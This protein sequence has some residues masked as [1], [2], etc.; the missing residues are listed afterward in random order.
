MEQQKLQELLTRRRW[1]R[2]P[3]SV[4]LH[5]YGAFFSSQ[6]VLVYDI[7]ADDLDHESSDVSSSRPTIDWSSS[8]CKSQ[9]IDYCNASASDSS[10]LRRIF[11]DICDR[12]IN[13]SI[14]RL[15]YITG[16]LRDIF[17]SIPHATTIFV[18][19]VALF[20]VWSSTDATAKNDSKRRGRFISFVS[21]CNETSLSDVILKERLD[22]ETTGD[23]KIIPNK[24]AAQT[25]LIK[26][27][28]RLYYKQ[29]KFN[30]LREES[31][32]YSK[33]ITELN[34]VDDFEVSSMNQVIR[35]LIGC[36]N[37]DPNR[38]L[39]VMLESFES[40]LHLEKS[41]VPL[42]S[43]FL[44]NG[45]TLTQVLALKFNF[46]KNKRTPESL[47]L[48]AAVLISNELI[49]L[50]ELLCYLGPK[51]S[52]IENHNNYLLEEARKI[53]RKATVIST[54]EEQKEE[55]PFKDDERFSLFANNQ[56]LGLCH[57]LTKV[58]N[59]KHSRLMIE[60]LMP[61]DYCLGV[62]AICSN[63]ALSLAVSIDFLYSKFS[64]LPEALAAKIP[65]ANYPHIRFIKPVESVKQ[66]IE[67]TVP[68][69]C[70]I[71]PYLYIN[72]QVMIKLIRICRSLWPSRDSSSNIDASHPTAAAAAP[73][74]DEADVNEAI[75]RSAILD[76]LDQCILPAVTV[77][78][79]NAAL[80]EELWL[81]LK[82]I[83]YESRYR[84]YYGWKQEPTVP[85][86]MKVRASS[87]SKMKYI[88]KRLSKETWK[89]YGRQI[90]K[91]SHSNPVFLFQNVS[92]LI[93]HSSSSSSSSSSP[94][95]CFGCDLNN[96]FSSL[97]SRCWLKFSLT[98]T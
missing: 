87:L 69:I 83:P 24:K 77:I 43:K 74:V 73:L 33:L 96:I 91:L 48:L 22:Y 21:A 72:T 20:D 6:L 52:L 58:G 93:R 51:D 1:T 88:M 23:A 65:R 97:S 90:G 70:L 31:E 47:Y 68:M 62:P 35:S 63:L 26:L 25:K 4:L 37:L 9:L 49:D 53:I 34:Q 28:T 95:S 45:T 79:S 61:P 55:D 54:V 64:S 10:K 84:L 5:F 8:V 86:L 30:L 75:L 11:Y 50:T 27:K 78:D 12:A 76:I 57:A 98:I 66:F 89:Q 71:G 46:Y 18:D 38:V 29:Q 16:A 14:P 59:W 13:G 44:D 32:G 40:R 94:S 85:L 2:K 81:L 92:E 19:V 60:Q 36:F 17:I 41:Y 39:D 15:E 3:S 80:S 67:Q 56:K 42:I 7:M 82:L